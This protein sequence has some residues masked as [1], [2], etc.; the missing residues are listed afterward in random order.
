MMLRSNGKAMLRS[1]LAT[2]AFL[3]TAGSPVQAAACSTAIEK[4]SQSY[5]AAPPAEIIEALGVVES[6]SDC[7]SDVVGDAKRQVSA[8]IAQRAQRAMQAE[9]LGEADRILRLAPSLHWA[10]LA[11]RG[12]IAAKQGNRSEAAGFYNTAIDT[13][14]DPA[15]TQQDPRLVP[16]ARKLAKV[17]QENMMLAGTSESALKRGGQA[18]GVLRGIVF[19]KAPNKKE[20]GYAGPGERA[21]GYQ[22]ETDLKTANKADDGYAPEK[23]NAHDG[24]EKKAYQPP[25]AEVTKDPV[26]Y[27]VVA[28]AYKDINE[29]FLPIRFEFDSARLNAAGEMEAKR[30]AALLKLHDIASIRIEGHTDDVGSEA[31]NKDLS[32]R[33]AQSLKDFLIADGVRIDIVYVGKGE[34]EPPIFSDINSYSLEER[35]TVMR[36]VEIAFQ[37]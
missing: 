13:L 2:A 3:L 26:K 22:P 18:S 35:R 27:N 19:E 4:L 20:V 6:E 8:V 1:F 31:Y 15:L 5:S 32:V 37:W 36:R 25:K 33:R 34:H 16:V 7:S 29:V 28:D 10:V 12:D 30:L 21:E 24:T 23:S 11:L 17:A 9:N 14:S